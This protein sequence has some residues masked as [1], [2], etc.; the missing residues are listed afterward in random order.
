M[1]TSG[2]HVETLIV[3]GGLAGLSLAAQ[4]QARGDSYRLVEARRRLGGRVLSVP[5]RYQDTAATFDMG[6]AWFWPGQPRIAA[7]V[8]E[9]GLGV[10]DQYS[11][12][13]LVYEDER[14]KLARGH[15]MS[16]EGSLRLD[17]GLGG[18]IAGL[19][20]RLPPDRIQRQRTVVSVRRSGDALHTRLQVDGEA[21]A[22]PV[23]SDRVVLAIPPR[24]AATRIEFGDAVSET[25][26]KAMRQIPTWMAGHAKVV[27]VYATAFWRRAGLAGDAMS[28][29]GPLA[30]IHDASPV[31]GGPY[32]LFGF[33]GTPPAARRDVA[34]LKRDATAQ[35][36]RLFGDA[37]GKPIDVLVQDWALQ[38]HTAVAL[39][40]AP[41]R[42]H[43]QYGLVPALRGLCD[44]RVLLGSTE[45]ARQFGGYLEGAL[46]AAELVG[47]QLAS[48]TESAR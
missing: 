25:A 24:V 17:G 18:L 43:P 32:A 41:L 26:L 14:G 31:Q 28:R 8:R 6:P 9:L 44:G 40:H 37:A 21:E 15:G 47:Q 35:L 45:V 7:L 20:D 34:Q 19:A 22:Q 33:V 5:L 42:E 2:T 39:D 16:M 23:S 38:P 27:A 1:E 36:V 10:F 12:G 13:E 30:E 29:I 48:S 3:G 4:L 46:E 11:R